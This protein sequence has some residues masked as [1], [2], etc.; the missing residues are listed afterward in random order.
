[1]HSI[2]SLTPTA[3]TLGV[4]CASDAHA[5]L[6]IRDTELKHVSVTLSGN[7][8]ARNAPVTWQGTAMTSTSPG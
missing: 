5:G 6:T 7:R 1:M 3:L 2:F 8:V 4:S